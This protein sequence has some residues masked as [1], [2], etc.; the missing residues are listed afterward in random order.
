MSA[1][2]SSFARFTRSL[3][4]YQRKAIKNWQPP[5]ESEQRMEYAGGIAGGG[6]LMYIYAREHRDAPFDP[7]NVAIAA[8]PGFMFG[9]LFPLLTL[10]VAG[11]YAL[12]EL[13]QK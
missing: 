6:M 2:F 3:Q 1:R 7:Y 11:C 9:G 5:S 13:N 10:G 8:V 12:H 4:A